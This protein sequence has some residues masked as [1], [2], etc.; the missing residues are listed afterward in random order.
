MPLRMR[1][2]KRIK[3]IVLVKIN[4]L[5]P[6]EYQIRK[7]TFDKDHGALYTNWWNLDSKHGMDWEIIDYINRSSHQI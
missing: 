3:E 7:Y 4:G 5:E 6:G 1:L 2:Q